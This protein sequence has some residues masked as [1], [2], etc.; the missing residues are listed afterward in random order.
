MKL[1]FCFAIALNRNASNGVRARS[2]DFV[3][4]IFGGRIGWNDQKARSSSV[5]P[6]P[7]AN[8]EGSGRAVFAPVAIH[9]LISATCSRVSFLSRFGISPL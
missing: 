4:G 5:M 3:A 2:L 8:S 9:C 6:P 7:F 1:S